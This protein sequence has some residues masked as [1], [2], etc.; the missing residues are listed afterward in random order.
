MKIKAKINPL[1]EEIIKKQKEIISEI[2][3]KDL[4]D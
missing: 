2:K 3:L 4:K 1:N